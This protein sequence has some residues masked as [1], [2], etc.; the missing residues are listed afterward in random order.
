MALSHVVSVCAVASCAGVSLAQ[1][2]W[3]AYNAAAGSLPTAQGFRVFD[4]MWGPAP[5]V[6]GGALEQ[7]PTD[8]SSMQYWH[9]SHDIDFDRGVLVQGMI[10]VTSSTYRLGDCAASVRFGY[11]M[12]VVDRLGRMAYIGI[13]DDK[14]YVLTSANDVPTNQKPVVVLPMRGQWRQVGMQIRGT[15]IDLF[16]DGRFLAHYPLGPTGAARS[17][18]RALFGD[19]T[20]CGSS[21]TLLKWAEFGP[22]FECPADFND[23]GFVDFSDYDAFVQCFE[24]EGCPNGRTA[25]INGD[26]FIDFFDYDEFLE[27]FDFGCSNTDG[28]GGGG[29]GGGNGDGQSGGAVGG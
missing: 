17:I 6:R 13:S 7:G 16:A 15:G 22:L 18:N 20:S 10:N 14:L 26:G 4:D 21:R 27:D 19:G 8:F 1:T 12:G 11:Y 2:P 9:A 29:G 28:G 24:G 3:L 25:D 23:D 5:V